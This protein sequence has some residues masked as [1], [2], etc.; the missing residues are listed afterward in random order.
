MA[1]SSGLA[2]FALLS[3]A[4]ALLAV[5][6]GARVVAQCHPPLHALCVPARARPPLASARTVVVTDMDETLIS[7]KSTGY[8]INFLVKL[9]AFR[10]L[11]VPLLAAVSGPRFFTPASRARLRAQIVLWARVERW[12]SALWLRACRY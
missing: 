9:R 7:K 6:L 11:L 4:A 1:R 10:L 12:L 8:V 5:P 3:P 2:L